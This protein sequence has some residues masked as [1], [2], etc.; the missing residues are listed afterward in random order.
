MLKVK[1]FLI[2]SYIEFVGMIEVSLAAN[3]VAIVYYSLI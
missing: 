3:L 1:L 2:S